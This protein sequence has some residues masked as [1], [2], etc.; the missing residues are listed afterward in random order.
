MEQLLCAA[1]IAGGVALCAA[2]AVSVRSEC[3]RRLNEERSVVER[4]QDDVTHLGESV[5]QRRE[6]VTK[7]ERDVLERERE[8]IRNAEREKALEQAGGAA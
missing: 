5:S 4:L 1:V 8:I 6:A 7:L 3:L 2:H